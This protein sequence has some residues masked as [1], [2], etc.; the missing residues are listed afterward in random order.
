LEAYKKLL[1]DYFGDKLFNIDKRMPL[2]NFKDLEFNIIKENG[3]D[4]FCQ[5]KI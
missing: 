1:K 4:Y 5:E 2:P 3:T